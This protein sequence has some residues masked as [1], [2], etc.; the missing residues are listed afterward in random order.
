MADAATQMTAA[1][2][3]RGA[4]WLSGAG[5]RPTRQ[6]IALATLLVGDGRNRHVTAES[7]FDAATRCG[8]HARARGGCRA[9]GGRDGCHGADHEQAHDKAS[10]G[11]EFPDELEASGFFSGS[12]EEGSGHELVNEHVVFD[13]E[14]LL[15]HGGQQF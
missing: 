11:E 15:V 4:D 7:L 3:E 12:E 13:L 14:T 5:L 1:A 2:T 9:P 8:A 10:R 6:R